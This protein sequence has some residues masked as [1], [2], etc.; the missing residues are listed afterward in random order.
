MNAQNFEIPPEIISWSQIPC[1]KNFIFKEIL[2][3]EMTIK[4]RNWLTNFLIFSYNRSMNFVSFFLW[5][6]NEIPYFFP[7][8]DRRILQSSPTWPINKFHGIFCNPFIGEFHDLF[9]VFNIKMLWFSPLAD[10]WISR[11]FLLTN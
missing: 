6:I 9:P 7:M 8:T 4:S 3:F 1:T 2:F 5:Q 11:Y 10:S